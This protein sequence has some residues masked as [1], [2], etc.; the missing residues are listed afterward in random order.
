MELPEHGDYDYES[1]KWYCSCWQTSKE[2]EDIHDYSPPF[3]SAGV[4][5]HSAVPDQ[6]LKSNENKLESNEFDVD[7]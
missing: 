7:D 3:P 2:W 1:R 4:R 5:V 6:A